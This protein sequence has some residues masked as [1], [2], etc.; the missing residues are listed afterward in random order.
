[1]AIKVSCG[2]FWTKPPTCGNAV[3]RAIKRFTAT[4]LLA[5]TLFVVGAGS[6]EARVMVGKVSIFR[7][8][9]SITAPLQRQRFWNFDSRK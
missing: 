6:D 1:M 2:W 4:V 7:N 3:A 5:K 8:R 9:L